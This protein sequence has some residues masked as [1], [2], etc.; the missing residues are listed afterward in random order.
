[1]ISLLYCGNSNVFKGL[2]ISLLSVARTTKEPLD[3]HILTMNL[4]D[5]NPNYIDISKEQCDY[6][7]SILK[8]KNSE[9]KLTRYDLKD[10]F[11]NEMA[12]SPNAQTV[13]TPYTLLRLFCDKLPL[14]DRIIYMDTDTMAKKDISPLYNFD[15]KGHNFAGSL[16][17]LGKVF[18]N[19]RYINA[20]VLLLN[21]Q[22]IK[23]TA[24]MEKARK[25]CRE[26]KMPFPDQD[27]INRIEKNKCFLPRCFNEQRKLKQ[28]TVIRHFSKSI[29][30][31]PFF[32]TVNIKPWDIENLH[33][34]YHCYEFDEC[35]DEYKRYY[36]LWESE[37]L[38][39]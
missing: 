3:V 29:R 24:F 18:I 22:N 23:Q 19:P 10:M 20:G 1:M 26:K 33:S 34:V 16:D 35:L 7:E 6:L 37:K 5:T 28:D 31:F 21:T 11:I 27:A 13:Y 30:W 17:Y 39:T 4:V 25:L 32:H 36:K 9:S 8:E 15:V 12:D 2:M 14:P 38:L